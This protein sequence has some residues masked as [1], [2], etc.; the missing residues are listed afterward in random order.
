MKALV[1][2]GKPYPEGFELKEV[3]RPKADSDHAIIKNRAQGS[4]DQTY[5]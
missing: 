4:V 1:W 3:E 5:T 2:N